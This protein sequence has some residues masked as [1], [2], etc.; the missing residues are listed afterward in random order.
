MGFWRKGIDELFYLG[1]R[2]LGVSWIR[3]LVRQ[4]CHGI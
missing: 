2:R 4:V 1:I 3:N